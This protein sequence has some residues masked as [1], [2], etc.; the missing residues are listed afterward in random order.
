MR[1]T[2]YMDLNLLAILAVGIFVLRAEPLFK[3]FNLICNIRSA[4][5]S[6]QLTCIIVCVCVSILFLSI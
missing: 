2:G 1:L 3:V 5:Y 4:K 6:V